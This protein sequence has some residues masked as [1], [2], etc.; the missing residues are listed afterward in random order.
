MIFDALTYANKPDLGL[1]RMHQLSGGRLWPDGAD[2][3][4]MPTS[5]GTLFEFEGGTIPDGDAV[6]L[7]VEHWNEPDG[8]RLVNMLQLWNQHYPQRRTG[9]YGE[10]PKRDYW[11]AIKGSTHS[12]Y[13]EWQAENDAKAAIAEAADIL[14]PSLYTFYDDPENWVIYAVANIK[15]AKRFREAVYPFLWPQY[16]PSTA[17]GGQYIDAAFFRLQ[18][19]VCLGLCDGVVIWG[20]WQQEWD[21][22]FGWWAATQRVM[23]SHA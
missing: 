20:G 18:L 6:F 10:L 16:H 1:P 3:E 19:E 12:E 11:R 15:E 2:Q 4:Q 22:D 14:H 13:Q 5:F 17:L 23:Q 9:V 7:N 21:D 8:A